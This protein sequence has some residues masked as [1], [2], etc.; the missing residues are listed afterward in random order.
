MITCSIISESL[1][2]HVPFSPEGQSF[3][4]MMMLWKKLLGNL[5]W[6]IHQKSA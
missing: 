5:V 4:P 6:M 2:L 1:F 3:S